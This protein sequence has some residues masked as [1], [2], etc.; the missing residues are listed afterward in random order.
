MHQLLRMTQWHN[1]AICHTEPAISQTV[2]RK[3]RKHPRLLFTCPIEAMGM[4][5]R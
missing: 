2:F 5:G 4:Q 3:C 1:L